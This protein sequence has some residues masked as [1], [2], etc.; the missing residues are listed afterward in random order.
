MTNFK[1][2]FSNPWLLLLLIPALALTLFPY[3]RLSR[4]YRR[5]RNRVVSVV[6]HSLVMLLCISLLSG[7]SFS[8]DVPN[9]ENE[10]IVLVDA[11]YSNRESQEKKDEFIQSVIDESGRGFSVGVVKFGYDQVYAAPLSHDLNRVFREYLSSEEPDVSATDF[12][13]ALRYASELFTKPETG[14][15]VLV[16]DGIET[17][18]NALGVVKSLAA[19]GIKVDVKHFP[20]EVASEIEVVGIDLPD[21]NVKAGEAF[22]ITLHIRHNFQNGATVSVKTFDNYE[23]GSFSDDPVEFEVNAGV[24]TLELKHAV[25]VPGMHELRFELTVQEGDTLT[26]NNNY[27]AYVKLN[28]F[29]NILI[30]EKDAGESAKL[31]EFLENNHYTVTVLSTSR[32]AAAMPADLYALCEY[33]QVVLVN[34]A[35]SDLKA[36]GMP[37]NFDR[38]LYNY[39]YMQGGGVFTVGGNNDFVDGKTVPHAYNRDDM[40][41]TVDGRRQPTLLQ[42]MLPVQVVG[43]TP[44]VAVMLVI[45]HSG[46]ME[47]TMLGGTKIEAAKQGAL[48]SIDYLSSRDYIGILMLDIETVE[49]LPMTPASQKETIRDAI[50]NIPTSAQEGTLFA[51]AMEYAGGALRTTSVQQRH[52]I[53]VTD[54]EPAD[55]EAFR[56]AVDYNA[57]HGVTMSIVT[58]GAA[59]NEVTS[60]R[61]AANRGKGTYYNAQ[62]FSEVTNSI[63]K[64]FETSAVAEI[65]Y[66]KPFTPTVQDHTSAVAGIETATFPQLTG[67][68]GTRAKDGAEVPLVGEF[69]PIY[70]QWKFGAG[71]VGSFMCD[72]NGNW[73]GDFLTDPTGA[74]FI[75]NVVEG[76]FPLDEIMPSDI[77]VVVREDNYTTQL[78]VFTE[79]GEGEKT[80]ISIRPITESA[81]DYYADNPIPVTVSD[82]YSRFTLEITQPGLYEITVMK[83]SES[84]EEISRVTL[85]KTFSYSAEYDVFPER[86][87]VGEEFLTRIAEGGNGVVINDVLEVFESF[88]KEIHKNFDPRILFLILAIVFFLLDIAVRKFKFKWPH[89]LIRDYKQKKAMKQQERE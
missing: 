19:Q 6:L 71:M 56:T 33:E 69:V 18:G 54:G 1:I 10:I 70:A 65:E 38:L 84:G 30:I 32:D 27:Y 87:P 37:E 12:T 57:A 2:E 62:T 47:N 49:V 7:I 79:L 48:S 82:G 31:R 16:S 15:I 40:Y 85:Y 43:Y 36:E 68:Y 60:M 39:V 26:E 34:I 53:L 81:D 4:K 80:E 28:A 72:L 11:S 5:N 17:D 41:E 22:P 83:K 35:N 25:P 44:P 29:S 63:A 55:M 89:E 78:N 20:D 74:R 51:Q 61:E 66:G 58:C 73:S 45:D 88:L 77:R 86:E 46:S 23:S 50:R 59:G 52:I 75:G 9:R 8:Y 14:K 24:Q 21:Y 64:D 13:S 67:Y 3:F 42:Q 76:L